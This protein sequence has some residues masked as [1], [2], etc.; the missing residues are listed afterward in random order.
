M[1]R[2][3]RVLPLV[4][5]A[6]ATPGCGA[7][8]A[9]GER[10]AGGGWER[11]AQPPIGPREPGVALTID[12]EA[13]FLGG[14]DADPCP[15]A[16]DCVLPEEPPLRDGAAFD[17]RTGAW[18][19]VAD[20]PVGFSFA[21]HAVL[22]G[23]AYL[24]VPGEPG[25]PRAPGAFLR[26]GRADD[27]WTRLEP[28]PDADRRWLVAT[29]DRVIAYA[30]IDEGA[31][32]PDLA[33]DPATG[34][35]SELPDDPLSGMTGRTMAWSGDALVL[36]TTRP[37]DDG[38]PLLRAAALDPGSRSWRRL[39]DSGIAGGGGGSWFAHDGRLVLPVL[40]GA[41][42]GEV[43]NWGATYPHGGILD[44]PEGRWLPLPDG[45]GGESEFAAGVVA[46]ERARL[47]SPA[48][49]VLDLVAEA[50][51]PVPEL[52]PDDTYTSRRVAAA[53]RTTIAF[54]GARFGGEERLRG[55]LL[56]EAWRWRV[57]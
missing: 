44:V 52:D 30:D 9:P 24:L 55:E 32:I 6:V 25:R 22:G 29:D 45:P 26:Y 12:Q 27:R 46:G 40:G 20:A 3:A 42:G 15:P 36:F 19:R 56:G 51:I 49:W 35:W 50:W 41:D 47:D 2:L 8:R 39:P 7:E 11:L 31:A 57:P 1:H 17:A 48:G 54:G 37:G 16:A 10:P 21:H 18:T 53:G 23:H 33:F 14:S 13:L 28:P 34:A 5:L 38:P 43:G 4:L